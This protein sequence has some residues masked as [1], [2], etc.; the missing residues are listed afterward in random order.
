MSDGV[1]S[2]DRGVE[3]NALLQLNHRIAHSVELLIV[4]QLDTVSLVPTRCPLGP[5]PGDPHDSKYHDAHSH[6]HHEAD[7]DSNCNADPKVV[8]RGTSALAIGEC[9]GRG[10]AFCIRVQMVSVVTF[11]A[12]S[13]AENTRSTLIQRAIGV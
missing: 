13:L 8:R 1:L 4:C 6:H 10:H 5:L 12:S 3:I 11:Q 2:L 7:C 9:A